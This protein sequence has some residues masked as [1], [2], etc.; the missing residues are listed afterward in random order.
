[1]RIRLETDAYYLLLQALQD[2]RYS[3]VVSPMHFAEANAISDVEERGEVLAVLETL[4][5]TA[6]SG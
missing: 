6:E 4:G 1:M 5:T 2:A 3:L